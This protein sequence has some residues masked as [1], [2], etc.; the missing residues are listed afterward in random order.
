MNPKLPKP[1][2]ISDFV[3]LKK[4]T[5]GLYYMDFG[6]TNKS[7]FFFEQMQSRF[8]FLGIVYSVYFTIK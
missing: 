5:G 4:L 8:P 6:M 1:V 2:E 3:S 7:G